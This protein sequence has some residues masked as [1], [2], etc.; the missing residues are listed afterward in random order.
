M[1]RCSIHLGCEEC[2]DGCKVCSST[3][4][5]EAR[6]RSAAVQKAVAA[7]ADHVDGLRGRPSF[8]TSRRNTNPRAVS[9]AAMQ[10]GER[11]AMMLATEPH[12]DESGQDNSGGCANSDCKYDVAVV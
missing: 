2:E 12:V 4:C 6:G 11:P 3:K 8:S 9:S 1:H 5:F 10:R 7:A